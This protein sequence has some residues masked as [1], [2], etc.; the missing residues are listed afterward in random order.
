MDKYHSINQF[1]YLLFNFPNYHSV[2]DWIAQHE[3]ICGKDHLIAKWEGYCDTYGCA[4]LAWIQL[5][6]NCDAE[7]RRAIIDYCTEVFEMQKS[8]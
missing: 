4:E 2:F 8:I 1:V 7:I 6:L 3:S 5:Y